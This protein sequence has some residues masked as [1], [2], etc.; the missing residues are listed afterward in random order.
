MDFNT[1]DAVNYHYDKFPLQ[2]ASVRRPALYSVEP[3]L[4]IVR[5]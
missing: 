2:K 4:R 1:T 5:V 3:L